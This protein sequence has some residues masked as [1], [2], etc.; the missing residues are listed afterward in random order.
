MANWYNVSFRTINDEVV[1]IIKNGQTVD[2][3]YDKK[4]QVGH[5]RLKWGLS[6]IDVEKLENLAERNKLSFYI[7]ALDY[8]TKTVQEFEYKNGDMIA[9]E[10]KHDP[11]YWKEINEDDL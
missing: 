10:S 6:S 4:L 2:F 9:L 11:S 8:L 7:R 1:E 5:C 3:Y